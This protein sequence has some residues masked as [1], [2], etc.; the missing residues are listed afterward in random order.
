MKTPSFRVFADRLFSLFPAPPEIARRPSGS[1]T[2][3]SRPR[4][5]AA[6]FVAVLSPAAYATF[7]PLHTLMTGHVQGAHVIQP[8][9]L[10]RALLVLFY[11][12]FTPSLALA[13]GGFWKR[14]TCVVEGYPFPAP[15]SIKHRVSC[16]SLFF[17]RW[18]RW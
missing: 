2:L 6:S 16:W 4:N 5:F 17:D 11:L 13:G 3:T 1:V 14:M 9:Q 15:T 12:S 10:C 18:Q 7:G 8:A